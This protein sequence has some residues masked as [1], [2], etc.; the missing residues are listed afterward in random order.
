MRLIASR[1]LPDDHAATYVQGELVSKRGKPLLPPAAGH[2]Y[3]IFASSLNPGAAAL[4]VEVAQKR[5]MTHSQ[6]TSKE[7]VAHNR[8]HVTQNVESLP[9]CDRML[10]LLTA[11]TWT[12]GADSDAFG[13]EV[14]RAMRAQVPLLL[15]Q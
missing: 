14:M 10:V 11:A 12:R 3:H 15:A 5:G 7:E 8:L 13:A 6:H 1:V 2:D 4:M 9:Q